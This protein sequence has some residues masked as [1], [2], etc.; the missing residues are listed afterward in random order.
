MTWRGAR[1]GEN[2]HLNDARQALAYYFAGDPAGFDRLE[3][4]MSAGT[5]FERTVWHCLR[6]IPRGVVRTYGEIARAVGRPNAARAVGGCNARNPWAIV[7][8]CHRLVGANGDL[9]GYGGGVE[10][11]KRLL[12]FEGVDL[13]AFRAKK[14]AAASRSRRAYAHRN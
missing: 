2:K 4:D 5:E 12:E 1:G 10:I 9:V 6:A 11:K 7:V 13:S 8:P 14:L 3:L